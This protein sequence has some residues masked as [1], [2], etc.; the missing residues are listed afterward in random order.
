MV[1]RIKTKIVYALDRNDKH[2]EA[3]SVS[4][5]YEGDIALLCGAPGGQQQLANA[6]TAYYTTL[7][8]QAQAEYADAKGVFDELT[9]E[10]TPIFNA[11]PN[12]YGFSQAETNA[13][14]TEAA[15]G[16]QQ[17]YNMVNQAVK[18]NLAAQGGNSPMMPSGVA[19]KAA[20]ATA[21]AGASQ[22]AQEQGQIVQS[23][24]QQG[25][26]EWLAAASGLGQ[27][28]NVFSTA[29]GAG[30]VA[31]QGGEAAGQT[32]SAIAAENES[33][34]NAVMGALGGVGSAVAG[35]VTKNAGWGCW[36]AAACFDEDFHTGVKT[37]LV[38]EW[39]WTHAPKS[40]LRLYS[41]YG[42]WIAKQKI[43]VSMLTPVFNWMLKKAEE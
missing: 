4:Y 28:E 38:R 29:N 21:T 11:G 6:Q 26:N 8:Q 18:E 5:L 33:P 15:T 23:G 34:F 25:Y 2:V 7:T 3:Y 17:D 19:E 32:W 16:T 22:L 39:M 40:V 14:N 20:R 24:Y 42:Q 37:N 31:N 10:Y 27:A 36:V 43:L 9:S 12:Q 30:S 1:N 41:R 13:L 35:Q